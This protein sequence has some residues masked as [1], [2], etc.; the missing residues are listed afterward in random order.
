MEKKPTSGLA[1]TALIMGIIALFSSFVPL[2]NLL[3]FPF[4]ILAIIFGGIGLWQTLCRSKAGKGLAIAGLVLGVLALLVTFVMYGA[5]SS[6]TDGAATDAVFDAAG[7]TTEQA[8]ASSAAGG[9]TQAAEPAPAQE[10]DYAV[11]IDGCRV[12]E[13]YQ[14]NPAVVVTYTFANNSDEAKSFMVAL[15]PKVFQNGVELNTA[16]GSDWDSEKYMSDVKPGASTTVEMGYELEDM[17]DVTVEVE[18]L[19]SWDDVLL[20]EQTFSL[21]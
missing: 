4:V 18:E 7:P 14:G 12:T 1:V 21:A 16:I 20:A 15:S 17:S 10:V 11:T 5:A 6:A 13:D 19:F 9:D 2:L 8:D 3:S